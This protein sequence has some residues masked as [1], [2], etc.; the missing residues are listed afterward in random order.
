MRVSR[1][2]KG[3]RHPMS[4]NTDPR[5]EHSADAIGNQ[6]GYLCPKCGKGDYLH[7]TI[8]RSVSLLP[9]GT[10]DDSGGSEFEDDSPATCGHCDWSGKVGEF[11]TDALFEE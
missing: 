2:R 6:F 7:V 9:D 4:T 3:V 8:L 5:A 1:Y 10:E 11:D